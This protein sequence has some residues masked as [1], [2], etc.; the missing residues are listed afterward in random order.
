MVKEWWVLKSCV[1]VVVADE[2]D[3]DD[4]NNNIPGSTIIIPLF[5]EPAIMFLAESK[6]APPW[7][8]P[9]WRALVDD[10]LVSKDKGQTG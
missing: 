5:I 8:S 4:G 3:D 6:H 2:G 1:V 7:R 9:S 10:T